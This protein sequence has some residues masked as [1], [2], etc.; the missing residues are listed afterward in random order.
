MV[1]RGLEVHAV[2]RTRAD[3]PGVAACHAVDLLDPAACAALLRQVRPTHLLHLAWTV[4]PGQFWTTRANLDWVMAS[5]ALYRAFV[6]EGGSRFVGAGTCAEYDW[7]PERVEQPLDEREALCAPATL[8]GVS[9]HALH[10]MLASAAA[11]DGVSL[12]WGRVF[13]LYGP[14]EKPG[15]LVSDVVARLLR[16]EPVET[17]AGTQQRDFMHVEDVAAAFA[18]LLMSDV[19]GPVNIATGEARSLARL[20]EE[21]ARQ[22]GG[23]ALLRLGSRP[24]PANE[25]ARLLAAT[26]RLR[27][28]VGFTPR[29]GLPDGIADV[30]DAWR[31]TLA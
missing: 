30:I 5:L 21:I 12:A 19:Q 2:A 3:L 18:A 6:A 28:E 16:G 11:L 20:L 25:P 22:T 13:F 7:T 8:Y 27:D 4:T 24:M 10:Q 15:R 26:Q 9:K 23:G 29:F 14:G 17:T 31:K 1:A